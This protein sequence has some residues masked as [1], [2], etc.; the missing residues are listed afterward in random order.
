MDDLDSLDDLE[1]DIDKKAED[2]GTIMYVKVFGWIT[3]GI[4]IIYLIVSFFR[5]IMMS[6]MNAVTKMAQQQTDVFE[7]FDRYI[8]YQKTLSYVAIVLS[9]LF[10]TGGIGYALRREWGR[11]LYLAVCAIGVCYHLF[12]GYM[13]FFVMSD[14]QGSMN[15][16]N[17]PN[18]GSFSNGVSAVM[19]FF[20]GIIPI[21]YLVINLILAGRNKTRAVMK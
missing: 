10:I 3:F 13:T 18:M 11:K 20:T 21:V 9:A 2:R 15:T 19:W 7:Y 6:M 16:A 8:A 5:L 1:L 17:A 12:S 4:G 14:L